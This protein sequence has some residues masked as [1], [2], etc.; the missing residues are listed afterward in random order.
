MHKAD[1]DTVRES[2]LYHEVLA[3]LSTRLYIDG[4]KCLR[5]ASILIGNHKTF[6]WGNSLWKSFTCLF[7]SSMDTK[8][9]WW[10]QRKINEKKKLITLK[11]NLFLGISWCLPNF[12]TI[13]STNSTQE[14]IHLGHDIGASRSDNDSQVSERMSFIASGNCLQLYRYL[15]Y[16]DFYCFLTL[17]N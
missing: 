11:N 14:L 3:K 1:R 15:S 10:K 12:R 17:R 6:Y 9:N 16:V 4:C 5:L 13:F 7:E 8:R 2:L